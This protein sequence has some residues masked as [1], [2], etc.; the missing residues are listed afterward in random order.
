VNQGEDLQALC[1]WALVNIRLL[2][3]IVHKVFM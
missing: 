2:Q 1:Q 3:I